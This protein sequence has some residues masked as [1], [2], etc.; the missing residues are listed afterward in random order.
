MDQ[1]LYAEE[2]SLE[3]D[4][5]YDKDQDLCAN[6]MVARAMLNRKHDQNFDVD[7]KD[8]DQGSGLE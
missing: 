3:Q 7:K 6:K 8:L 2:A 1:Y 4:W 5:D